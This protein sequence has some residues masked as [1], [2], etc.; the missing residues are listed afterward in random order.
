[1]TSDLKF[2]LRGD[3]LNL[4]RGEAETFKARGGARTSIAAAMELLLG[5][6]AL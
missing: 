5:F 4:F 2:F 1:M 6:N 3:N